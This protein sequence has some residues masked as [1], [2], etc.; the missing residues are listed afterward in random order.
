MSVAYSRVSRIASL[1]GALWLAA[2]C[3]AL[4]QTLN[5]TATPTSLSFSWQIGAALPAA[6]KVAV[7]A[8]AGTPVY[9]LSIQG[10]NALW[11]T[12]NP[13][14][15]KM[16]ANISVAV[17][18]TSLSV[19]TYTAT[20]VMSTIPSATVSIPVTLVVTQ[21]LPTLQIST[22]TLSFTSPP[23]PSAQTITL[24]TTGG[25]IPFT[26][27]ATGASW[28]SLS[29]SNDIVLPGRPFTLTVIVDPSGLNPQPTPY[30]AKV[31]IVATGVPPANRSQNVTVNM[32][33]SPSTPSITSIWPTAI[34]AGSPATTITIRGSNFYKATTVKV[35][36]TSGTTTTITPTILSS[37]TMLAVLPATILTAADTL[38]VLVANPAPGGNSTAA[39]FTVSGNP[40][41]DA[42]VNVASYQSGVVS[43]GELI[44]LFGQNI[45]PAVAS[46]MADA[47][48][49]GF[50]DTSVGE[51]ASP[52]IR[53]R[54]R[55]CIRA[56]IRS[57][58]KSRTRRLLG[59]TRRL[60]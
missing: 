55:S 16:P 14:S 13:D 38:S 47:D 19:G 36:G 40:V 58:F 45:G 1:G 20:I 6:Q 12:A 41:V 53:S 21:P 52:S 32:T 49:N 59:E 27:A 60:S 11:L 51:S 18:P 34:Q 23:T 44:T 10:T 9:S 15:G 39:S 3:P 25:P 42:V 8:T 4:A 43:P 50:V 33:V 37:T 54:R 24:S 5:L 29:T 22:N 17:N 28:I 2:T 57:P 35:S 31:T 46:T 30:A 7:R 56:R 48:N 26:A